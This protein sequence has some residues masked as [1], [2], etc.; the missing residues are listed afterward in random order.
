M[1]VDETG[2]TIPLKRNHLINHFYSRFNTIEVIEPYTAIVSVKD[3]IVTTSI[4]G[5]FR[6]LDGKSCSELNSINLFEKTIVRDIPNDFIYAPMCHFY[7]A[8]SI[9]FDTAISFNS[10][11]SSDPFPEES[12]RSLVTY[13][14]HSRY[15]LMN[16]VSYEAAVVD[17]VIDTAAA[18]KKPPAKG[19]ID[20]SLEKKFFYRVLVIDVLQGE[21][22]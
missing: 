6:V 10:I 9:A 8:G 22:S 17:E 18:K 7:I 1:Q 14:N 19:G 15:L 4:T 21:N 13:N 5:I 3:L 2:K 16:I 11:D 12:F 20:P